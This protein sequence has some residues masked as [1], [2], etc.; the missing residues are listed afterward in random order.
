MKQKVLVLAAGVL[1]VSLAAFGAFASKDVSGAGSD[2]H[3]IPDSNPVYQPT[4]GHCDKH[5]SDIKITPSGNRVNVPCHVVD[6][7]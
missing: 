1:L 3:G 4:D 2:V 6:G 5:E 7:H